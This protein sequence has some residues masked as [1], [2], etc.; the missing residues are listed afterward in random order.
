MSQVKDRAQEVIE[1]RIGP[2]AFE[3]GY[4]S[5]ETVAKLHDEIDF[6]RACQAY[7]WGIP[8]VGLYEWRLAHRDVLKGKIGEML[9]Y[10]DSRRSW[11]FSRRTTRHRTLPRCSTSKRAGRSCSRS[12]QA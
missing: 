11:A 4:P 7:L 1:T 12:R 3:S 8:A 10:L 6:Q 9:S 5:Q 2:L